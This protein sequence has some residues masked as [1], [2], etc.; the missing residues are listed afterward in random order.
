MLEEVQA[1]EELLRRRYV[2]VLNAPPSLVLERIERRFKEKPARPEYRGFSREKI[3]DS[4]KK[5]SDE[6]HSFIEQAEPKLG[7]V[8][9]LE[10]DAPKSQNV[11]AI[12]KFINAHEVLAGDLSKSIT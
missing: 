5:Q 4:V 3:L 2:I 7:G 11:G 10:G 8:L 6:I 9:R 1:L 12:K